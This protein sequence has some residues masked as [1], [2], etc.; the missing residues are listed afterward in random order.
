MIRFD[1]RRFERREPRPESWPDAQEGGVWR[2][3]GDG[4]IGFGAWVT[5]VE[6][7]FSTA[8]DVTPSGLLDIFYGEV[9]KEKRRPSSPCVFISHQRADSNRGERIAC[10]ADHCGVDSWLD[11]Y[12]P[13]LRA[14]NQLTPSD[15][16]RSI[17]IAAIIEMALLN[18]T[19]VIALHTANSVDS[20]WIP[21]E[22]GRAKARG[23][24]SGQAAG[25]FEVGQ[26]LEACG[27]YVQLAAM[28]HD[29][30]DVLRWL[31]TVQGAM[32]PSAIGSTCRVHH[33]K[34]L[35]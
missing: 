33:T 32:T 7:L 16:R 26:K 3:Y 35:S 11:V 8:G 25:W 30:Q 21:Y 13:T 18:A 4:L 5:L 19:H 1:W 31:K 9:E 10:L 20:R 24:V 28:T 12:D 27:D 23:I 14:A 22:L 17:L 34:L 6:R 2:R 15:P 29:E